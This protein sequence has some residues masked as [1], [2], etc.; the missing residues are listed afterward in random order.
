MNISNIL[1]GL[2]GIGLFIGSFFNPVKLG[3]SYPVNSV[4]S[5]VTS[6]V[7]TANQ[8]NVSNPTGTVTLSTPQNINITSTPTFGNT[9]IGG[10]VTTTIVGDGTTST[11]PGPLASNGEFHVGSSTVIFAKRTFSG[12][13]GTYVNNLCATGLANASGT[14][15]YFPG[16]QVPS[17]SFTTGI[18]LTG[19]N[20]RCHLHGAGGDTTSINWGGSGAMITL[21][22]SKVNNA[23]LSI[24]VEGFHFVNRGSSATSSGNIGIL[25]GGVN[26]AAHQIVQFNHFQNFGKCL[27]VA[28]NTYDF[29][30]E[31]NSVTGCGQTI[32]IQT[33]SNSTEGI[34]IENNWLT[35]PAGNNPNDCIVAEN[36]GGDDIEVAFNVIDDCQARNK[37][38]AT[39]HFFGNKTEHPNS[40]YPNYIPFLQ[41]DSAF[42]YMQLD[43]EKV[44]SANGA[45]TGF[46]AL[47]DFNGS[48]LVNGLTIDVGNGTT[49]IPNVLINSAT[50]T[51]QNVTICGVTLDTSAGRVP[52]TQFTPRGLNIPTTTFNGCV[53]AVGS[54]TT[55]YRGTQSDG[56]YSVQ[57]TQFK[58]N[59]API[60]ALFSGTNFVNINNSSA[61]TTL[62]GTINGTTTIPANTLKAGSLLRLTAGGQWTTNAS[63]T[64]TSYFLLLGAN[65]VQS[66]VVTETGVG[67]GRGWRLD[68]TVSVW[69]GGTSG[70]WAPNCFFWGGVSAGGTQVI[71]MEGTT[72]TVNTTIANN[73][74]LQWLYAVATST[75][76]VT[77][78]QISFTVSP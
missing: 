55:T 66:N 60:G 68:C 6:L 14:D 52:Y 30:F 27:V 22:N 28:T 40:A 46:T 23:L 26:G 38:G 31:H 1:K 17:S 74:D 65:A 35:D 43:G 11:F 64:A 36:S 12:D 19:Q 67:A 24:A 50:S 25:A 20:Q 53:D 71:Y 73:V 13:F 58:V 78:T 34:R 7:G 42:S 45:S 4:T 63:G 51:N 47:F 72:S 49:S 44:F 2:A 33:A 41:D 61:S 15:V 69:S 29:F 48:A 10:S 56:S 32:Q 77:S 8:I 62:I 3:N 5:T 59:N 76:A 37:G 39:M 57:T 16:M 18:S 70:V 21:D 75:N 54:A 9:T